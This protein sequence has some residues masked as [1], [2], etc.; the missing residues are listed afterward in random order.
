LDD[1]A[2]KKNDRIAFLI[3]IVF[4]T[5]V[6]LGT[7]A[8]LIKLAGIKPNIIIIIA[9]VALFLFWLASVI[10]GVKI[11]QESDLTVMVFLCIMGTVPLLLDYFAGDSLIGLTG[12]FLVSF[13]YWNIKLAFPKGLVYPASLM[14]ITIIYSWAQ[15][16]SPFAMVWA[17]K[18]EAN[19]IDNIIILASG[20][21]LTSLYSIIHTKWMDD[22]SEM[23]SHRIAAA[24]LAEAN[25][26]LQDYASKIEAVSVAQER[27][28]LA[29]DIHDILAH[30][31]TSI[32]VQIGACEKLVKANPQR[33]IAEL[34]AVSETV[35]ESLTEVRASLKTLR[36]PLVKDEN[37][38][39]S[40]EKLVNT[41]AE[42]TGMNIVLNVSDDFKILNEELNE[43]VYRILQE[44]ITNAYR[45]GHAKKVDICIWWDKNLLLIRISDNGYGVA[46]MK[47]G[48]GLKGMRE[49]VERYGGVIA[50]RSV[51][52][53]GFDLGVD[54]PVKG[55]GYTGK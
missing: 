13:M 15:Y 7:A 41:F 52:G 26:K 23:V 35:R 32:I 3:L 36:E 34:Q 2:I 22:V 47:E 53:R 42:I 21:V 54:I 6:C 29:R 51:V 50:W 31:L 9:L 43:V 28:R 17:E 30:T 44:G 12:M 48:L 24:R 38:S 25:I 20:V 10:L 5:F 45:H 40:W 1:Y 11:E 37:G 19:N 18:F 27:T 39:K 33:A 55:G 8:S 4:S 16:G 46:N 49:R 14:F